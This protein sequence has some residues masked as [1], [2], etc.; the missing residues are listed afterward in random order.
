MFIDIKRCDNE[1]Q[2]ASRMLEIHAANALLLNKLI[3]I[4]VFF[5]DFQKSVF[6][7]KLK[8]Y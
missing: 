3:Y 4:S 5:Y 1:T 7:T 2:L 6:Q 8:G